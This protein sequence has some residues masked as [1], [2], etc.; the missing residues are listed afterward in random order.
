MESLV[1]GSSTWTVTVTSVVDSHITVPG[2]VTSHGREPPG[3]RIS[4]YFE[5]PKREKPSVM[6]LKVI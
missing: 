6:Y 1:I 2:P 5:N 4:S 3:I